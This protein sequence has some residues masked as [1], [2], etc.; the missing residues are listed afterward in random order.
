MNDGGTTIWGKVLPAEWT[1]PRRSRVAAHL[2]D[3]SAT[4]NPT[5]R[6]AEVII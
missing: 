2:P 3:V 4:T 6:F 1:D 5:V